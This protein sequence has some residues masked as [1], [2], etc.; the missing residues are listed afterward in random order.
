MMKSCFK[1]GAKL[2]IITLILISLIPVG[3]L[4]EGVNDLDGA[5]ISP[6]TLNTNNL[7][8]ATSGAED[9]TSN[10]AVQ[11][12]EANQ[13]T[14]TAPILETNAIENGFEYTNYSD[15][16]SIIRYRYPD[17]N[18]KIEIP[19]YLGIKSIED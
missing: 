12:I 3:V 2:I 7:E 14:E 19:S 9:L 1:R 13:I 16:V 15:G 4:A 5:T 6:E 18:T 17:N 8:T 11:E 10:E